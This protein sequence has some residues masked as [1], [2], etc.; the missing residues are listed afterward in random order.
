M[1]D[2]RI[3]AELDKLGRLVDSS[4]AFQN[5][6]GHEEIETKF[7]CQPPSLCNEFQTARLFLSHIGFLSVE[8]LQVNFICLVLFKILSVYLLYL[9]KFQD[10]SIRGNSLVGLDSSSPSFSDDLDSLD[11]LESRNHD[12]VFVFYVRSGQKD[13]SEILSN[14]V[15][16]IDT[17]VI[18]S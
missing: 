2:D 5:L 18:H 13:S 6:E 8:S 3:A 17:I 14:T 15:I 16:L 4:T 12:A 10:N 7:E 9:L 1:I 11:R